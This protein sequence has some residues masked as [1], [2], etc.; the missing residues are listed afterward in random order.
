MT[1]NFSNLVYLH[2]LLESIIEH[3]TT[4]VIT[5]LQ[6]YTK[7]EWVRK[8]TKVVYSNKEEVLPNGK[9]IDVFYKVTNFKKNICIGFEI[10]TGNDVDEKQMREEIEGLKSIEGC[11]E[12]YLVLVAQEDPKFNIPYY[13]IPLVIFSERVN[14][15]VELL[16]KFVKNLRNG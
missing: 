15:V 5:I 13:F 9:R 8:I 3:D 1:N 7:D 10:K 6:A 14:I 12:S 11:D 4:F 16:N 2:D